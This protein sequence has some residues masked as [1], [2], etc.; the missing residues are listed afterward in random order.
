MVKH[1]RAEGD[2]N[3]TV[4]KMIMLANAQIFKINTGICR[5]C[6]LGSS[7]GIGYMA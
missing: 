2:Y 6:E 4:S 5:L 7:Y 1:L 3:E